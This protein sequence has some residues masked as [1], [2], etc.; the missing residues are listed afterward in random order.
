MGRKRFV[1]DFCFFG[2]AG[3]VALGR[4]FGGCGVDDCYLRLGGFVGF[5]FCALRY[6]YLLI[7]SFCCF[8]G[9]CFR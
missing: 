1:C 7:D 6:C 5:D 2:G 8:V 9:G 4:Q 3:D